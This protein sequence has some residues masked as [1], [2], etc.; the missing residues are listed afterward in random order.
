MHFIPELVNVI[1][2]FAYHGLVIKKDM[3]M[4]PYDRR[5]GSL[6]MG[7]FYVRLKALIWRRGEWQATYVTVC[8]FGGV[9]W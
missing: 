8:A 4:C 2:E 5:H 6:C 7:D 1:D 3:F 9:A